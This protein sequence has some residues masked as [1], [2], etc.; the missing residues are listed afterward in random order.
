M[1]NSKT[2]N[3]LKR[4]VLLVLLAVGIL[5]C[6]KD[7]FTGSDSDTVT[8]NYHQK[9]VTQFITA[10]DT[11][12]AYRVLGEKEGIPLLMLASLGSSMDDWDPAVTNGLAQQYKVIL[13]DIQGVGSSTGITPENIPAMADGVVKFIGALGLNKVNLLGFSMGSFISQQ[14]VLTNP[15]LVNKIILTGTGPK[16][17]EGLSNLPNLLKSTAGLSPEQFFLVSHFTTSAESQNAGK[18]AYERI[19]LRKENRDIPVSAESTTAELKAV[20]G[21]AQPYPDALKEL[22]KITN[23]V[24]IIQGEGDA[25]VP[26]VNAAKMAAS[27]TGAQIIRY[28]NAGHG[29]LYQYHDQFVEAV[30]GF[31]NK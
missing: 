14:I 9:T 22:G 19:Q 31:L 7:E 16:G 3:A 1:K 4:V 11:K 10:G 2:I 23:P 13:L 27:I 29:A 26:V 20:L 5:S 12:F 28:P 24:L 21:W 8:M 6:N 18:L 17:A 25:L 30:L 15:G